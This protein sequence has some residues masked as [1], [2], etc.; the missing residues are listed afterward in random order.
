MKSERAP[1]QSTSIFT[2]NDVHKGTHTTR[3]SRGRGAIARPN[4]MV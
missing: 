4:D 1:I 2:R 3:G